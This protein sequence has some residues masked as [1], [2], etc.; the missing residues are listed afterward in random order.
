MNNLRV[1]LVAPRNPLNIGAVARAM[2]NLGALQL[3]LVTP[4][5]KAYREARSAV[6]AAG[7]LREAEE[8]DDCGSHSGLHAGRRNDSDRKSRNQAAAAATAGSGAGDLRA[9]VGR[10]GG[11]AVWV[12]KMG[13]VERESE[14]L[15]LAAA[16]SNAQRTLLDES[17][18][19]GGG[20]FV[21]AE[22]NGNRS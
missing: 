11:D 10:Q 20:M 9:N 16:H 4:Y 5:E 2:S 15:S 13:I 17:G 22:A 18:A 8:F 1:V 14:P 21:G 6:G 12:G 7:V 19:G 3:R